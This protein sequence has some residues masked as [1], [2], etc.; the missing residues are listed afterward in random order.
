MGLGATSRSAPARTAKHGP[1]RRVARVARDAALLLRDAGARWSQDACY[2]L[3]SSLAFAGLFSI[4]PLLL[5]AA[6]I[7]GFVLGNDSGARHKILNSVAHAT[8][9]TF[10]TVLDQT[11]ASMQRHR[12]AR[13]IGA[14]VSAV[15]LLVG[16]S[17][18]FAELQFSLNLIWRAESRRST[19][20]GSAIVGA[21]KARAFAFAV[22]VFVALTILALLVA[23]TALAALR[24]SIGHAGAGRTFWGVA[25]IAISIGVLTVLLC[26]L[27]RLVPETRVTWR[28][29]VPGSVLT[30]VLFTVVKNVLAWYFGNLGSYPAYG[31]AGALLGLL[32]WIYVASVLIFYGA[33]FSR[34]YAE[35]FGSLARRDGPQSAPGPSR[36]GP[37]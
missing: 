37:D 22:V 8:S 35:R 36:H 7:V 11:L 14:V 25:D 28:D 13:G 24:G 18:V 1:L 29:V 3:G 10:R 21:L 27:Y 4:F 32:T 26:A 20:I 5:L 33:E 9:P 19:G 15:A 16:A 2:R 23:S 34:L 12:T 31:A 30:A 17:G 6:T